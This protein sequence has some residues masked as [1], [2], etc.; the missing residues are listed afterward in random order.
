MKAAR[1]EDG[2]LH[3]RDVE[4]PVPGKEEALVHITASGVCHSDLHIA[5]TMIYLTASSPPLLS[6]L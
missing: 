3:I 1:L 2:V 6:S 5:R 4:V